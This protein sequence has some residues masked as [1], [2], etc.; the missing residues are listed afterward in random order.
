[1]DGMGGNP[2]ASVRREVGSQLGRGLQDPTQFEE[3]IVQVTR[4]I[5]EGHPK[6]LELHTFESL[7]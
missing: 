6:D 2:E 5:W 4:T 1:M 7:L 3:W